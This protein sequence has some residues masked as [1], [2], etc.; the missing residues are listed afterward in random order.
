MLRKTSSPTVHYEYLVKI[1]VGVAIA[2]PALLLTPALN[3]IG[4]AISNK[5][6]HF[7]STTLTA[8]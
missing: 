7:S 5:V 1:L 8:G 2:L 3:C 4:F 6:S